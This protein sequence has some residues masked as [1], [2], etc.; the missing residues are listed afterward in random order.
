MQSE[1]IACSYLLENFRI[2]SDLDCLDFK[3]CLECVSTC[4][5]FIILFEDC[6]ILNTVLS[7]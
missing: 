7:T 5:F 3:L 1:L 6:F 2:L 4:S